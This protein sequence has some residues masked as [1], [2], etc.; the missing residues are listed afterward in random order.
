MDVSNLQA[1]ADHI[2]VRVDVEKRKTMFTKDIVTAT[3]QTI[4]LITTTEFELGCAECGLQ[5][6]G[7]AEVI[8]VGKNVKNMQP[9]DMLMIDYTVELN[10][11][12]KPLKDTDGS[13]FCIRATTTYHE[14]DFIMGGNEKANPKIIWKAGEINLLSPV[15]AIVRGDQIIVNDPFVLLQYVKV[16]VGFKANAEGILVK[17]KVED[18]LLRTI[19]CSSEEDSFAPGDVL[20]VDDLDLFERSINDKVFSVI[21]KQDILCKVEN[22]E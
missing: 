21:F 5:T 8:N 19:I 1:P 18:L 7:T 12:A 14:Q 6:V 10:Q 13:V 2:I 3:G 11:S 20:L 22:D 16:E 15:I 17:G 4:T 9:G